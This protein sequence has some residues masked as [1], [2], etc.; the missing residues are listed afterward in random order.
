MKTLG[1]CKN[2]YSHSD[3]RSVV[4]CVYNTLKLFWLFSMCRCYWAMQSYP[5]TQKNCG[6]V[7]VTIGLNPLES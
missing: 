1:C 5:D 4:N 2:L 6:W 3:L 7:N